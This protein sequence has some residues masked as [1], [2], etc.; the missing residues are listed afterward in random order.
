VESSSQNFMIKRAPRDGFLALDGLAG[1]VIRHIIVFPESARIPKCTFNTHL[2]SAR[3]M[4]RD[5]YCTSDDSILKGL[6]PPHTSSDYICSLSFRSVMDYQNMR[7][8][9]PVRRPELLD[10]RGGEVSSHSR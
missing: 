8:D 7:D 6:A 9:L 5:L 1:F 3:A 4:L 2:A 10:R